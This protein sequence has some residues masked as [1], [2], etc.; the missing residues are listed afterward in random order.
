MSL[1]KPGIDKYYELEVPS[2]KSVA[3]R[4]LIM[5]SLCKRPITLRN[6][7]KSTDVIT[8]L[9][10]LEA[11]GLDIERN[12]NS[13]TIV[14][15]FPECEIANHDEIHLST[16]DGGTT[17]RFLIALLALGKNK[18]IIHP[19]IMFLKRPIDEMVNAL[20][21]M[22]VNVEIT[23]QCIKIKGPLKEKAVV[24]DCSRSSQFASAM[25]M[26]LEDENNI[27]LKH[28]ETSISYYKMT[29]KIISEYQSKKNVFDIPVD[30]SSCSYVIALSAISKKGGVIK[31]ALSRD[32]FQPDS[33][34]LDFIGHEF[35]DDGLHIRPN[36]IPG[37][38]K[39][40]ARKCPDLIPTLVFLASLNDE[41]S[42]FTHLEILR[43]KESDRLTELIHLLN[44]YGVNYAF[45]KDTLYIKKGTF[46]ARAIQIEPA[47]D[48]RMVMTSFMFQ[49]NFG[50]GELSNTKHIDKSFPG[51][52][53]LMN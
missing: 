35:K 25:R 5:A 44:I 24:I 29:E 9:N 34:L 48:H 17:N 46:E 10:C 7:P 51:F 16:G 52:M 22:N 2:S 40:D 37:P 19:D 28:F 18:Y 14:N 13:L 36:Q 23:K 27:I 31:N 11:I 49:K 3:N 38:F 32:D 43:H 47:K 6:L 26:V 45:H 30:F 41:E 39:I 4:H 8:L 53:E 33:C 12:E 21:S 42:E 50:G 1:I 20:E 15:S